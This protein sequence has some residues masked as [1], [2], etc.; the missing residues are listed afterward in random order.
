VVDTSSRVGDGTI[1]VVAV[2]WGDDA[3]VAEASVLVVGHGGG[4]SLAGKEA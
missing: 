1:V 4:V 2:S 3:V